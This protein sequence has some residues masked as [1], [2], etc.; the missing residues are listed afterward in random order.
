MKKLLVLVFVLFCTNS[1]AE[2]K[3]TV[4]DF[5]NALVEQKNKL[6]THFSNEKA[7]T[8]AFQKKNWEAGK[9]Q[10][11]KNIEQIKNLFKWNKNATQD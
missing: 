6:I 11:A 1:I 5:T 7:D 8:I 9:I 10:L 4:S 3:T 2:E